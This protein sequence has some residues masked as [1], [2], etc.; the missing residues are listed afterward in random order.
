MAWCV[1]L[2]MNLSTVSEKGALIQANL[3]T[4]KRAAKTMNTNIL[5]DFAGIFL[6]TSMAIDT[7]TGYWSRIIT[8]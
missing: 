8:I 3:D 6:T 2:I 5:F 7:V 4:E 1:F